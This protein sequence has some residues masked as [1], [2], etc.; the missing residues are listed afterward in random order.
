MHVLV[1]FR[2]LHSKQTGCSP[3]SE[4]PKNV[5]DVKQVKVGC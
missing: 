5:K 1:F 2:E 3:S 4:Q